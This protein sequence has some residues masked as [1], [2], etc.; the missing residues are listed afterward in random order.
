[1]STS[2]SPCGSAARGAPTTRCSTASASPRSPRLLERGPRRPGIRC[3]EVADAGGGLLAERDL[4]IGEAGAALEEVLGEG[5]RFTKAGGGENGR[6]GDAHRA[7]G[8]PAV[9]EQP[10][11]RAPAGVAVRRAG[12]ER[13]RR[14]GADEKPRGGGQRRTREHRRQQVAAG[15]ARR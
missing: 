9:G 13:E 6:A 15:G 10:A 14:G 7:D 3:L 5:V 12:D 2:T 1:M 8:Q 4:E 11:G